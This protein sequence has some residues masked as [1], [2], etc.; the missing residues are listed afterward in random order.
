MCVLCGYLIARAPIAVRL[1][2]SR[3]SSKHVMNTSTLSPLGA[4]GESRYF[5]FQ[6]VAIMSTEL[7]NPYVS[8]S[9]STMEKVSA[10]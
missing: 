10:L 7:S 9:R 3:G 4:G 8:A 2:T 6:T 1:S 5:S